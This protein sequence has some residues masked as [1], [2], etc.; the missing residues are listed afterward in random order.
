[1]IDAIVMPHL[2]CR[3]GDTVM[4]RATVLTAASGAFQVRIEDNK[5]MACTVWVPTSE[6]AK[7]EHVARLKP[8]RRLNIDTSPE[9]LRTVPL[10]AVE[11]S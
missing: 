3:E 5:T 10:H 11:A 1:M 9:A 4:V 7:P 8:R 6:V 2:E